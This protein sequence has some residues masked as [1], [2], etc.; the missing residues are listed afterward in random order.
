[1]IFITMAVNMMTLSIK[2]L[3]AKLSTNLLIVI[4]QRQHN[5]TQ[6]K[7]RIVLISLNLIYFHIMSPCAKYVIMLNVIVLMVVAPSTN[8]DE[9]TGKLESVRTGP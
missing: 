7:H 8:L 9:V 4:K 3:I 1:M 5:A 6:H 2:E